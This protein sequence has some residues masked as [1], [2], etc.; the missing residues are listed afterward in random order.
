MARIFALMAVL[1]FTL[2]GCQ[3][4]QAKIDALQKEYDQINQQFAKDCSAEYLKVPP[5]LSPKCVDENKQ[6]KD[7][8]DRLQAERAKK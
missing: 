4:H 8:W 7:A 3:S 6:M 5:T 1:V 2:P